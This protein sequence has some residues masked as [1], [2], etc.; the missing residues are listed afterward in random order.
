MKCT[1]SLFFLWTIFA[2]VKAL[3]MSVQEQEGEIEI[4]HSRVRRFTCDVLSA[5]AAGFSVGHAACAGHCLALRYKGGY[6]DSKAVCVCVSKMPNHFLGLTITVA[7]IAN[8][9]NVESIPNKYCH[10][11]VREVMYQYT[12]SDNKTNGDMMKINV[13][14][15]LLGI[16]CFGSSK[17]DNTFLENLKSKLH[18]IYI[19]Y[20]PNPEVGFNSLSKSF[21]MSELK[22]LFFEDRIS[23]QPLK[24][25]YFEGLGNLQM[26]SLRNDN[27]SIWSPDTLKYIPNVESLRL[28]YNR[29]ILYD[30]MF[31]N[32]TNLIF[33]S[34]S[35]NNLTHLPKRVFEGLKNLQ[36]LH[37]SNNKIQEIHIEV[38]N[39]FTNLINLNLSSN[40]LHHL[41]DRI[42]ANSYQLSWIG[43]SDNKFSNVS[44]E[45]L[46]HC[47]P[48]YVEF[49]D[50]H[51]LILD[52][53]T[54]SNY[55]SLE[56][57]DLSRN[58]LIHLPPNSFSGS[59][60]VK[61]INLQK[62]SLRLLPDSIFEDQFEL[63]ELYLDF[64]QLEILSPN[65]FSSLRSLKI[66]YLN[67]NYLTV[68]SDYI[69][70]NSL[71]LRELQ[72]S[73]NHLSS[74]EY[75]NA[76]NISFVSFSEVAL[77]Y[78]KLR[79]VDIS[80]N[81]ITQYP[82]RSK[83][84]A[85]ARNISFENN[86]IQ[87]FNI[88]FLRHSDVSKRELNLDHNNITSI[89]F[90]N[91]EEIVEKYGKK[92]LKIKISHN[93]IRCDCRALDLIKY[94]NRNR[95]NDSI[96]L[97]F[98]YEYLEC[99]GPFSMR[100]IPVK[101]VVPEDLMCR[102]DGSECTED[103]DCDCFYKSER[104]ILMIDCSNKYLHEPPKLKMSSVSYGIVNSTELNLDGNLLTEFSERVGYTQVT[105]LYMQNNFISNISWLP[106]SIQV[107][108]LNNNK[109]KLMDSEFLKKLDTLN[110]EELNLAN[111]PWT[112]SCETLEFSHFLERYISNII[113]NENIR[114]NGTGSSI[115]NLKDED[116]CPLKIHRGLTAL[117]FFL[118]FSFIL[119]I[120]AL[121]FYI[122]QKTI[123]TWLYAHGLCLWLIKEERVDKSKL[124]DAFVS[125]AKED[126]QFVVEQLVP[127]LEKGTPNYKLCLHSRNW[128][129]GE[130]I[131]TQINRSVRVSRRT[132]IILS[133]NFLKSI[134]G[135]MEFRTAHT[136]ASKEGRVRVIVI[137]YGDIDMKMMDDEWKAY[138]RTNTY[139]KWGDPWFWDKLRYALPRR[140]NK[141]KN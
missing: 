63:E 139:I 82:R 36:G 27:I 68:M 52:D 32:S 118:F 31:Q 58:G 20:C 46:S 87:Y 86:F 108:Y 49:S 10:Q 112:C 30:N 70:R 98:Y 124:Y 133:T 65:V 104:N 103:V 56:L 3:P 45:L 96:S 11:S 122:Y 14:D 35:Y 60:S 91:I 102:L 93:P 18:Y 48:E 15:T 131:T 12:C 40:L 100:N 17:L 22:N 47:R 53:G 61:M 120:N 92:K 74:F 99:N 106:T 105:K 140:H 66:L 41:D 38:F 29:M 59:S 25:E 75:S 37:L 110:I 76:N 24:A 119:I 123:L 113:D 33:L 90:Q 81:E 83:I 114:C 44:K 16:E 72:L 8:I 71:N 79:N 7:L 115:I 78:P 117:A 50:N 88:S 9:Q 85:D 134:W 141:S 55:F 64:N 136:E 107:L 97:Q 62:N 138:M 95:V 73:H 132:L 23:N 84:I 69:L 28:D 125:Y 89:D 109:L 129:P 39:E 4:V 116:L 5:Q 43:L 13:S 135:K 34:I 2:L 19:H 127:N 77:L 54:F 121:L 137:I 80:H 42:F 26:L 94:L 6:C 57:L 126:Q 67:N 1:I 130:Y 111:N 21:D 128:V 51:N 101:N